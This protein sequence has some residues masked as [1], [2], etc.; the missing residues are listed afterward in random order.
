MVFSAGGS[1]T[2][3][4]FELNPFLRIIDGGS[5]CVFH[6]WYQASPWTR[7]NVDGFPNFLV[8]GVGNTLDASANEAVESYSRVLSKM[9]PAIVIYRGRDG[10]ENFLRKRFSLSGQ[11]ES[12][13]EDD[14][15][16][17]KR[18]YKEALSGLQDVDHILSMFLGKK[19]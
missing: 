2:Y 11:I 9:R 19:R 6:S 8:D 14:F 3:P 1:P 17:F 18:V 10:L 15:N 7:W 5:D 16:H 4:T 12:L 13:P